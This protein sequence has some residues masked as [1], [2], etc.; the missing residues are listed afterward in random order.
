MIA[1]VSFYTA[2]T[3]HTHARAR[4][5]ART[6]AQVTDESGEA[7]YITST[8][9]GVGTSGYKPAEAREGM[10]MGIGYDPMKFDVWS[11]G[12]I[13]FFMV[14]GDVVFAKLGGQLCFR[15][16]VGRSC[17]GWWCWWWWWWRRRWWSWWW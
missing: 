11:C 17:G 12:V 14:V 8:V 15:C 7:M 6:H 2:Q 16:G 10:G 1:V 5:H 9:V 13:L 3:T 4:A